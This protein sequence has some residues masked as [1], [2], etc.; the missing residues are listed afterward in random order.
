MV[1]FDHC[2]T[3]STLSALL[4]VTV[5]LLSCSAQTG[6]LPTETGE[7]EQAVL[8]GGGGGGSAS[9]GT[10]GSDQ[11]AP[12]I[13][14]GDDTHGKEGKGGRPA[15]EMTVGAPVEDGTASVQSVNDPPFFVDLPFHTSELQI[16]SA[17]THACFL[18]G[19]GGSFVGSSSTF[20]D[21]QV[22]VSV[23]NGVWTART[24][25]H[26]PTQYGS[27]VCAGLGWFQSA[28]G[29]TARWLSDQHWAWA[30][31]GG[32]C[33]AYTGTAWWGDA[34]VGLT[35][36]RGPFYGSGEYVQAE[37]GPSAYANG[38]VKVQD[39][40]SGDLQSNGVAG[41]S[42]FVGTPNSGQRAYFYYN[43][44]AFG[45]PVKST[46]TTPYSLSHNGYG[47]YLVHFMA[48][49]NDAMCF[50]T[51]VTGDFDGSSSANYA[52]ID[53][54]W[55]LPQPRWRFRVNAVAPGDVWGQA[56]CFARIQH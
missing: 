28:S 33:P 51:R 39:C 40:H 16:V 11:G 49:A 3:R 47:S 52:W 2:S 37:Q 24:G 25:N 32:G 15:Y 46:A 41:H 19:V 26:S 22:S 48:Y 54:D 31:S 56:R 6:D 44:F 42:L 45:N 5:I 23:V 14:A 20:Q 12:M 8:N 34:V 29:G 53:I 38:W 50:L 13:G 1:F 43:S 9:T 10:T 27:V 35:S 18:A 21:D 17:S 36:M 4:P 7:T 55:S 30:N